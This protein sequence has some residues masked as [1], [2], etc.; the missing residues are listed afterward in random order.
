MAQ[1]ARPDS[2]ISVNGWATT[3][4]NLWEVIDEVSASDTDFITGSSTDGAAEVALSTVTDPAVGT[5]HTIRIRAQAVGGSGGPERVDVSIFEGTTLIVIAFNN[6]AVNRGS[7]QDETYTLSAAEADSISDYSD[8]RIR[9]DSL[10]LAGSETIEISWAE[11]EVPD[12]PSQAYIQGFFRIRSGDDQPLN[13]D[14]GWAAAQN[15]NATIGNGNTFRVRFKVRETGGGTDADNFKLQVNFESNGFVD[16]GLATPGSAAT[17]VTSVLSAIFTDDDASTAEHLSNTV[18][19]VT[20]QGDANSNVTT[21]YSLTSEETEIEF[22]LRIN[23]W[24]N[25]G[26]TETLIVADDTFIL[27]VVESDGTVFAG[28]YTSPT[29]TVSETDGFLG[30]TAVETPAKNLIVAS[31][32][33]IYFLMEAFDIVGNG[34]FLMKSTD[35]G[36]TWRE[37]AT[38]ASRPTTGDLEGCDMMINPADPDMICMV[39]DDSGGQFYFEYLMSTDGTSPDTWAVKDEVITSNNSMSTAC[40]SLWVRDEGSGN[41]TVVCAYTDEVTSSPRNVCMY[42]I[43]S[44]GGTWGGTTLLDATASTDFISPVMVGDSTDRIYIFYKDETNGEIFYKIL[45]TN[46]TL[47]SR[48]SVATGIATGSDIDNMPFIAPRAYL[49]GSVEVVVLLYQI[50]AD[51][52]GTSR[53]IRDGSFQSPSTATDNGIESSQGGS[54]QTVAGMDVWNKELLLFYC[55]ANAANLDMYFTRN[56]DEGGWNTDVEQ[57]DAITLNWIDVLVFTHSIGNGGDTV[58]GYV[59]DETELAGGYGNQWYDELVV[60]AAPQPL[61]FRSKARFNTLIRM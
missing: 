21:G 33:D 52:V 19:Y 50:V 2:D 17:P 18:T 43:R 41:Y 51:A 32:G 25:Q 49:D 4:T 13:T 3:A 42:N 57:H 34:T 30:G 22:A 60:A 9:F 38:A 54:H 39:I 29:I 12:A 45:Q 56:D 6:L 23:T 20:G 10:N 31:N 61:L 7:F 5:G 16:V 58:A 11:L 40:I 37:G 46:D 24:Y 55:H 28:A 44:T 48:V 27:R 53:Y 8:L 14:A 36:K 35:G 47:E 26:G 59:Y 15:V 1:F